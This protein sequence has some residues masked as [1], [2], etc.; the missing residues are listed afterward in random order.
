MVAPG[1][2]GRGRRAPRRSWPGRATLTGV[3]AIDWGAA[4]RIGELIAGSPPYGGVHA[5]SVQ[6]L[7]YDFARRVSEYSGL[8]LPT[9]LPALEAV[10]R[11]GWIDANL[12]SMR[13]LLGLLTDR[14]GE[15]TGPLA[16]PLRS[17]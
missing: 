3:D 4:Q 2:P 14:L 6:P 5:D 8:A 13:P 16:G 12:R 17:A 1:V 15:G 11:A 10:D 7:A 9:E